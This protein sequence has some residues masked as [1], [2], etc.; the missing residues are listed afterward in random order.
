MRFQEITER[1]QQRTELMYHGTSSNLVPSIL[2]NG[3]LARPPKKTY[4][5]DTFG[6]ETASMDGVYV[7]DDPEFA[8]TIAEEAVEVHG[9]EPAMVT[10]QY[11]KNSADVDEDNLISAIAD[12][13][14]KVVTELAKQAPDLGQNV[15][16]FTDEPKQENPYSSLDY[17][18]QGWATDEMIK[19]AD[20]A[21]RK[22]ATIAL[23]ILRKES[24]PRQGSELLIAKIAKTLLVRAGKLKDISDRRDALRYSAFETI[25]DSM[26]DLLDKLQR[27]VSPDGTQG[28][29]GARRIDR[30][31]KFKGKTRILKIEIG[32]RQ[33]YP[34]T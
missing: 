27:Q 8:K 21:A 4:D 22:I 31:V 30:D 15:R 6:S 25:R 28:Q 29:H 19:K 18:Q 11:V 33:I 16:D 5:V 9:G 17:P 24:K 23:E 3:L 14:L 1:Q 10:L 26:P 7:A 20:S 12:A 13:M 2:K 34:K 32:N